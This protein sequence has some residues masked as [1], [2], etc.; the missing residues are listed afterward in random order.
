MAGREEAVG[1]F[2]TEE[3]SR[4]H[5]GGGHASQMAN[6][7]R[8]LHGEGNAR[9]RRGRDHH[10]AAV[11]AL[12]ALQPCRNLPVDLNGRG[13]I[14]LDPA[15]VRQI[16]AEDEAPEFEAVPRE[17]IANASLRSWIAAHQPIVLNSGKTLI[18]GIF[19]VDRGICRAERFQEQRFVRG[20]EAKV[21]RI[22]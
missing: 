4:T 8:H 14:I 16:E 13:G 18:G 12:G 17:R 2:E 7:I 5:A 3:H 19:N 11:C 1:L 9:K 20:Q 22:A 6:H 10:V 21:R 15:A